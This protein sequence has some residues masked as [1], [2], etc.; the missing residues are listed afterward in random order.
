MSS[1]TTRVELHSADWG[2]YTT[3]HT[4]MKRQG[5]RQTITSDNGKTYALPTAEYDLVGQISRQDVLNRAK[6]AAD[7]TLRSYE[8]I[9]TESAGRTWSGLQQQ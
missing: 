7:K 8:V 2:D 9:V 6:A 3:L 1:F 5:F 4:E